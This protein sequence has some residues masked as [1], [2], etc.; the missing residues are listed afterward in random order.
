MFSIGLM[1]PVVA[2]PLALIYSFPAAFLAFERGAGAAISSAL[3]SAC[4]MSI[5]MPGIYSVMYFFMFGLS[6]VLIGLA[7]KSGVAGGNLLVASSSV[8]FAGKLFAVVICFRVTGVNLM[9]PDAAEIET[10]L[11]SFGGASLDPGIMRV[12][13]DNM[14]LLIPYSMIMFA[15]VEAMACV[16]LVSYIHKKRT[17]EAFFHMPSFPEWSFPRS[18]LVALIAGFRCGEIASGRQ[19]AYML[20]QIGANLS[21]I[22]RTL[23]ILQGLSC[24]YFFMELRH[25]PRFLRITTVI[26][27]P[28]LPIIG[29]LLA[30]IGIADM[31]FDFRHR[32]RG[33]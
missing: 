12:F 29:A 25:I 17:G 20:R 26:L 27:A 6:G 24:V 3:A 14:I 28:F 8:E 23:F 33:T 11:A 7:A 4:I 1:S 18:L 30:I 9:S 15:A 2:L 5:V 22:S 32:V 31:G 19:D 10:V 13:I 21:E 16:M